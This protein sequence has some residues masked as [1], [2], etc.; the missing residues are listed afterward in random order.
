MPLCIFS[1]TYTNTPFTSSQ[2]SLSSSFTF[3]C[4]SLF[5][6]FHSLF[7]YLRQEYFITIMSTD[8]LSYFITPFFHHVFLKIIFVY[9]FFIQ[10][11]LSYHY[12]VLLPSRAECD[13]CFQMFCFLFTSFLITECFTSINSPFLPS[14]IHLSF[15]FL[16]SSDKIFH[17]YKLFLPSFIHLIFPFLFSSK[18]KYFITI[19]FSFIPFI[20]FSFHS[21]FP[22][23]H[24]NI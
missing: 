22:H 8:F 19:N 15:L 11:M 24:K 4:H 17:Y 10:T 9:I 21:H 14:F 3:I 7:L 6:I 16:F 12:Q 2:S 13:T 5:S 23:A 20:L 18:T 1:N